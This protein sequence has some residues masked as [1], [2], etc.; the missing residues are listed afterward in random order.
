MKKIVGE[1]DF[2]MKLNWYDPVCK[3]EQ[4]NVELQKE[5]NSE[6]FET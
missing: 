5:S 2:H 1:I 6:L 4:V 3:L